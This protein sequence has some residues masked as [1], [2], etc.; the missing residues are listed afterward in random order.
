MRED[1]QLVGSS[2]HIS[3]FRNREF[4]FEKKTAIMSH[5]QPAG[6]TAGTLQRSKTYSDVLHFPPARK[7]KTTQPKQYLGVERSRFPE[8]GYFIYLVKNTVSTQFGRLLRKSSIRT[9]VSKLPT[10][11]AKNTYS[12]I[13]YTFLLVNVAN[14]IEGLT[15]PFRNRRSQES[16]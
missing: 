12:Q 7:K 11:L 4:A 13:V 3:S 10:P 2:F 9:A 8:A 5:Q 16:S 15:M 6:S 1:I 14:P